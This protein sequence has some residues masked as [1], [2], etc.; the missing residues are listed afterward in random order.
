MS[1]TGFLYVLANSSMPGLVKVG[2]TIRNPTERAAEL[3]GVTGL[4]TPFIVV[5]EQ[6]FQDCHAAESFVHAYLAEKGHKVADNREFFNA[7]VNMVI[8]AISLAPGQIDDESSALK[9]LE[10]PDELITGSSGD[11]LDDLMLEASAPTEPWQAIFDEAEAHYYGFGDY[12]EDHSEA[13]RLFRQAAKLGST[14][15]YGRIGHQYEYGEGTPKNTAKALEFYKE[16]A[17]KGRPACYFQM[18]LMFSKAD[19]YQNAEKCF[20]IFIKNFSSN[21][22]CSDY[23]ASMIDGEL[24]AIVFHRIILGDM[25]YHAVFDEIIVR[26]KSYVMSFFQRRRMLALERGEASLAKNY[27]DAC[28]YIDAL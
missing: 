9:S 10:E 26:R 24:A 14:E 3:S 22:I 16:G 2:R 6:L 5:Y 25:S 17:R 15:A 4:A 13:L 27:E 20:S 7:S 1:K 18:A 11:E 19:N 28:K 12:I 21:A 8:R 23:E